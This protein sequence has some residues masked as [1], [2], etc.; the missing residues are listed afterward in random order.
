VWVT[1]TFP[2]IVLTI[3]LIRGLSLPGAYQGI[4][5]YLSPKLSLL[6]ETRVRNRAL[7]YDKERRE[8]K[9]SADDCIFFTAQSVSPVH[10]W[11]DRT[12]GERIFFI[13]HLHAFQSWAGDKDKKLEPAKNDFRPF[14]QNS[15]FYYYF[16]FT[17]QKLFWVKF[18][19][20]WLFW[21]L[22]LPMI[23]V[24]FACKAC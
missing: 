3:L 20:F 11:T 1:A 13:F 9:L 18:L 17:K 14:F 12:H 19:I 6:K 15:L 22:L 16:F 23:S 8:N 2:Y 4:S 21:V 5:Y 10:P 7:R 24:S